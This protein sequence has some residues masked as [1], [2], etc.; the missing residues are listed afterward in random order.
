M[1]LAVQV[2]IWI[3]A[4]CN[5]KD[6][7]FAVCAHAHRFGKCLG[8]FCT[9]TCLI[10]PKN[11]KI[12]FHFIHTNSHNFAPPRASQMGLCLL[13]GSDSMH[14]QSGIPHR[15]KPVPDKNRKLGFTTPHPEGEKRF[16][17]DFIFLFKPNDRS[18]FS[19]DP[20][21]KYPGSQAEPGS[22]ITKILNT[23]T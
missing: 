8:V 23:N 10:Y 22:S 19:P 6:C 15:I 5:T 16:N 20:F 4:P 7:S 21:Q 2:S 1:Y 11:F 13:I 12:M 3:P 14:S 18:F 9:V 17:Q